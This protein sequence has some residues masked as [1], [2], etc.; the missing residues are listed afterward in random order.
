MDTSSQQIA[1]G[2]AFLG[3]VGTPCLVPNWGNGIRQDID[4]RQ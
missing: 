2:L 1:R 3:P 4:D